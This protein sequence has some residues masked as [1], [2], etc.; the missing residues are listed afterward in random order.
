MTVLQLQ[1][2]MSNC[3]S[4]GIDS[5]SQSEI[6]CWSLAPHRGT[7]GDWAHQTVQASVQCLTDSWL[8]FWRQLGR[9]KLPSCGRSV[10]DSE[11]RYPFYYATISSI[12]GP[13]VLFLPSVHIITCY[14][15]LMK[16][17]KFEM[18]KFLFIFIIF[19][20]LLPANKLYWGQCPQSLS[21]SIYEWG[22]GDLW[23]ATPL[24]IKQWWGT[25][26]NL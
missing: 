21:D 11:S 17:R 3:V 1:F 18:P 25:K 9:S 12:T 13:N 16:T 7:E 2:L 22:E 5:E 6:T 10:I 19:P 15:F 26:N 23:R 4:R 24:T 8:L 20:K 14:P